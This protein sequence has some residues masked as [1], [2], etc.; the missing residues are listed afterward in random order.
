MSCCNPNDQTSDSPCNLMFNTLINEVYWPVIYNKLGKLCQACVGCLVFL[1]SLQ[2]ERAPLH[3]D[4]KAE[5]GKQYH[6]LL[7][8]YKTLAM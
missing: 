5:V 6:L 2:E 1:T 7:T 3:D 4:T 8:F